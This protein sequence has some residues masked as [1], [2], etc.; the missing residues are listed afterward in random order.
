[1]SK[2]AKVANKRIGFNPRFVLNILFWWFA[3]C[4]RPSE[5]DVDTKRVTKEDSSPS[6]TGTGIDG[7]QVKENHKLGIVVPIFL[8]EYLEDVEDSFGMPVFLGAGNYGA[9][10]LMRIKTTRRCAVKSQHTHFNEQGA[11]KVSTSLNYV[12]IYT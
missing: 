10:Q 7:D 4:F 5:E 9:V 1:M 8:P 11:M 2:H 3:C 6:L 12:D